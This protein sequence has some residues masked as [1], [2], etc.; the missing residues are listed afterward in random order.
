MN[1]SED[2]EELVSRPQIWQFWNHWFHTRPPLYLFLSFYRRKKIML[3]LRKFQIFSQIRVN[4]NLIT[5]WYIFSMKITFENKK[6]FD[7]CPQTN[8]WSLWR[9]K[10]LAELTAYYELFLKSKFLQKILSNAKI[11]HFLNSIKTSKKFKSWD[12][13]KFKNLAKIS[14]HGYSRSF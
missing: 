5:I 12:P 14:Y 2:E 13:E 4:V 11:I 3:N 8:R 10:A 7:V 9:P 6:N 1:F